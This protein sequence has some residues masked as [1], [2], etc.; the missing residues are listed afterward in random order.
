MHVR[1]GSRYANCLAVTRRL[2]GAERD[3]HP[4]V[5]PIALRYRVAAK[6]FRHLVRRS[7]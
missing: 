2:C 3:L 6:H 4:Q 5:G 1:K 7:S